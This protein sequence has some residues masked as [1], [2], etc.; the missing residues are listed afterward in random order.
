MPAQTVYMLRLS[1]CYLTLAVAIGSILLYHKVQPLHPG[2]W[3]LL[4]LHFEAAIW[5][6]F[7]QFVMGTAYWMFPRRLEGDARG[8]ILLAWCMVAFFN[9]GLL[10]LIAG[11]FPAIEFLKLKAVGR[12][13]ITC[14]ILLFGW[15]IWNRVVSYRNLKH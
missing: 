15:L 12:A 14:S 1:L 11:Y 5:G 9:T 10:L 6:W 3:A 4:P 2:V 8:S 13:V 7:I